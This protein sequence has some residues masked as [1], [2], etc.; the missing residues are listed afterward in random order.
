MPKFLQAVEQ[1]FIK[2]VSLEYSKLREAQGRARPRTAT[3]STSAS[4]DSNGPNQPQSD[5]VLENDG[6][7]AIGGK[8][9]RLET[10]V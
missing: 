5:R 7:V 4:F 1:D 10:F 6:I 9:S 2:L 3:D 8:E